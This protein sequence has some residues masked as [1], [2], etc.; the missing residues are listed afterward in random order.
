MLGPLLAYTPEDDEWQA[1]VAMR[2]LLRDLYSDTLPRADLR[3]A[4]V[5]RAYRL[6][7]CKAGYKLNCLFYLEEDVTLAVAN[8]ARLGV[9]LG[10]VCAHVVESLNA[11]L[12]WA[13]NDHTARARGGMPGATALERE[14]EVAL[15]GW[16]CWFLK[17]YLALQHH[18]APHTAQCT[19]AK[20]MATQSPLLSCFSSPLLALVLPPHGPRHEVPLGGRVESPRRPRGMLVL[21]VFAF[22]VR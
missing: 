5:A 8:A 11:I 14:A 1:V 9:C 7:C 3:A 13:Y 10:A 2:D 12:K 15:Q 18:G 17:F 19:I 16:E 21:L 4:E 6:H 20:L 22:C